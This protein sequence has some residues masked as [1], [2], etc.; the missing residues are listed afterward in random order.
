MVRIEEIKREAIETNIPIVQDDTLRFMEEL[1]SSHKLF[2]ILELGSATGYSAISMALIDEKINITTIERDI[3]RYNKAVENINK[4]NLMDRINILNEDALLIDIKELYDFIFIDAA[5]TK[6]KE[7]LEKYKNNL[8][9]DG[10]IVID[11]MNFHGYVGNSQNIE[12]KSL[13]KMVEK[14]EAFR[15]YLSIQE[16]F[17]AEILNIGDGIAVLKRR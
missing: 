2:S 15:E 10:Y 13:R 6:N 9:P 1:I 7:F 3:V 5:N 11:N 17:D 8:K 4:M 12:S 14:I 16:E